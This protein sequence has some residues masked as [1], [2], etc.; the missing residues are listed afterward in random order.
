[1]EDKNRTSL[2]DFLAGLDLNNWPTRSTDQEITAEI[3]K[4]HCREFGYVKFLESVSEI[5]ENEETF[6]VTFPAW[7][8]ELQRRFEGLYGPE[9]GWIAFQKS[10][11]WAFHE[12]FGR[13]M[14]MTIE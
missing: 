13:H 9:N 8:V 2:L 5:D 6:Q 7:H 10:L 14:A 11:M 12:L 1:M 3:L 4:R